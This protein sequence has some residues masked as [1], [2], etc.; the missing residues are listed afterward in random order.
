MRSK[1]FLALIIISGFLLLTFLFVSSAYPNHLSDVELSGSIYV[2][3]KESRSVSVVE[4]S[5]FT[6]E[7]EIHLSIEPH[8][9]SSDL[10]ARVVVSN[11]GNHNETGR[12]ISIID[13][14]SKSVLYDLDMGENTKPHDL[15]WIPG[16]EH[17]VV[18]N[19]KS[20]EITL[21]NIKSGD[22]IRRF[23]TGQLSTHMLDVDTNHKRIYAVN[24]T[25]KSITVINYKSFVVEANIDLQ[26]EISDVA[27]QADGN[28]FWVLDEKTNK[29]LVLDANDFSIQKR[30]Q[31]G[32]NPKRIRFTPNGK[33]ALITNFT[34]GSVSILDTD[35]KREMKRITIPGKRN[36]LERIFMHTPTPIGLL[37]HPDGRYALI[38]NSNAHQLVILD[39]TKGK[40]MGSINVGKRPD[41]IAYVRDQTNP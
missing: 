23:K 39:I 35:S 38:A 12:T 25:S 22:I 6:T 40:L 37:V 31:V 20:N 29:A 16:T 36:Y 1:S 30:I 11:Y 24:Q 15:E 2:V 14:K 41:G 33:R 17:V 4:L 13:H 19:D 8:E 10:N 5:S 27:V 34:D 21:A 28:T 26:I 3:N 9:A 7:D 18:A 32:A